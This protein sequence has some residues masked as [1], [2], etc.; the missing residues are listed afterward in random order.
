MIRTVFDNKNIVFIKLL[1][2]L[3]QLIYVF[4]LIQLPK[5]INR[6]FNPGFAA[7]TFPMVVSA[8]SL[9]LSSKIINLPVDIGYFA[10]IE[11]LIATIIV[12]Y[13]FI[14]YIKFIIL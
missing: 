2:T 11:T 1:L 8:M 7:F 5:L 12:G 14:K 6:K 3:S 13:V 4:V 9:K 10:N